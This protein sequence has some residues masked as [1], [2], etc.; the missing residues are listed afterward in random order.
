MIFFQKLKIFIRYVLSL[1][2]LRC[3][4]RSDSRCKLFLF[5]QV[6]TRIRLHIE[7]VKSKKTQPDMVFMSFSLPPDTIFAFLTLNTTH[8]AHLEISDS[9]FASFERVV[10]E[11]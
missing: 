8:S 9:K 6:Y 7:G 3:V 10:I 1:S 4:P 11:Y 5:T 2:F